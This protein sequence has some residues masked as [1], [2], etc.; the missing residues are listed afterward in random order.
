MPRPIS[1]PFLHVRSYI[2]RPPLV[3]YAGL[4]LWNFQLSSSQEP[5]QI[6]SLTT[7]YP[8][9]DSPDESQFYLIIVDV[10]LE[11]MG[12]PLISLLF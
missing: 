8:L 7:L 5:V 2:E 4:W 6:D 10:D 12:A 11:A 9:T 1:V 3:K